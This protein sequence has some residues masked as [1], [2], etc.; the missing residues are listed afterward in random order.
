MFPNEILPM[1]R[2]SKTTLNVQGA[3]RELKSELKTLAKN[4]PDKLEAYENAMEELEKSYSAGP[5]LAGE[6]IY[7]PEPW[8]GSLSLPLP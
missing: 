7:P 4:D 8:D 6:Q 3:L 5:P 1:L 2:N